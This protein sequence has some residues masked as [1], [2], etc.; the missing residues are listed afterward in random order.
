MLRQS[1]E[2]TGFRAHD[3]HLGLVDL[4]PLAERSQTVAR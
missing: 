1:P 4:D 3:A 2:Q